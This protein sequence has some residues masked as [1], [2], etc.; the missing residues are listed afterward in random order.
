[1]SVIQS[2]ARS[3]SGWGSEG[4]SFTVLS[5]SVFMDGRRHLGTARL[6]PAAER[7]QLHAAGLRLREHAAALLVD[8][9]LDVLA[10]RLHRTVEVVGLRHAGNQVLDLLVFLERV[11]D[12]LLIA[13]RLRV[14]G[15]E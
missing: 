6:D 15:I 10:D 3:L 2:Y 13:R 4:C 1:M 7:G 12:H 9:M 14:R 8:V 11:F 5:C